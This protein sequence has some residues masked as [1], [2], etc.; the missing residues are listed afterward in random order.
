MVKV[1]KETFRKEVMRQNDPRIRLYQNKTFAGEEQ[2]AKLSQHLEHNE[3]HRIPSTNPLQ[4]Q[5][6]CEKTHQNLSM[7]RH[8]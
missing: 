8:H 5:K 4:I 2:L 7:E 1:I 3:V 6:S